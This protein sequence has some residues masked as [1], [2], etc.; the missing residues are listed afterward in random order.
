MKTPYLNASEAQS[1]TQA[2][3]LC[4]RWS[5]KT[6]SAHTPSHK[7]WVRQEDLWNPQWWM[8]HMKVVARSPL[9]S[10]SCCDPRALSRQ[11]CRLRLRSYPSVVDCITM[12][13]GC[14]KHNLGGKQNAEWN[15]GRNQNFYF[16]WQ[17][18]PVLV[19]ISTNTSFYLKI[20]IYVAL[21]ISTNSIPF[22]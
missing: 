3:K 22:Y 20:Y 5:C 17:C 21:H 8:Q 9:Y 6:L 10:M 13:L 15:L 11:G 12:K 2:I 14:G 7:M 4:W 1:R 16:F 18:K 19:E